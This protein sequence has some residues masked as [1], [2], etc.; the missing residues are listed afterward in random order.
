M[1]SELTLEKAMPFVRTALSIHLR[2]TE[3]ERLVCAYD[4]RIF[5]VVSGFG[6][7]RIGEGYHDARPGRLF[8]WISGTPYCFLP[9]AG[10]MLHMIAVN[11]DFTQNF[12]SLQ[13]PIPV[14]P[15]AEF[16]KDKLLEQVVFSNATALNRVT[17]VDGVGSVLA[18]LRAMERECDMPQLYTSTQ[19]RALLLTVLTLVARSGHGGPALR[20]GSD[21]ANRIID[22]VNQHYDQPLSNGLLAE[23]FGY[24]PN[25]ISQLIRGH[26][27]VSLHQY[28]LKVRIRH[29]VHLLENTALPIGE[30]AE[31]T[32]FRS[33]SYFSK[34]FRTCTGYTPGEFRV[35]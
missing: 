24:H 4:H 28:L 31:K 11:F 3:R 12:S 32:G 2:H 21:S 26:T 1:I 13:H 23:K 19:L 35:R 6:K 18:Y 10:Q 27:G 16:Q 15:A 14:T 9:E 7:V 20:T 25:Y 8:Y 5:Y 17:V 34:Y 33:M 30:I 22:Y 29:A